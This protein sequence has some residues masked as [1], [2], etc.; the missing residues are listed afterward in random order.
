MLFAAGLA[1][2]FTDSL[3]AIAQFFKTGGWFM[4]PIVVCSIVM[5]A[6]I[7]A[8]CLALRRSRIMPEPLVEALRGRDTAQWPALVMG[9]TSPLAVIC[10][11][12]FIP[13]PDLAAAARSAEATGRQEFERLERGIPLLEIIFTIAPMLGLIGTVAGL[14]RIFGALGT[15]EEDTDRAA[16]I[17][18]GIA[19]AMNATI[20]G[21]VVAV[22]A[23]IAYVMFNRHVERCASEMGVLVNRALNTLWQPNT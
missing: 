17:A 19:E 1:T 10:Q 21:L 5:V 4:F 11:E 15:A 13:H 16:T 9:D 8:K 2:R 12:S 7:V 22:P 6:V 3:S 14:V 23:L 18:A 20:A